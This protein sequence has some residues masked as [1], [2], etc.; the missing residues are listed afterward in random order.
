MVRN[1]LAVL[2]IGLFAMSANA[3]D[4]LYSADTAMTHDAGAFG[5][6]ANF[7][8]LM[9]NS[10]FDADGNKEDWGDNDKYTIMAV[11]ITVYY[12]IMDNLEVGVQPKFLMP[13]YECECMTR[14]TDT[15]EGSGIGDTWI[16]AKY[17]FMPEPMMTARLGF[18]IPTGS[19][20]YD[21]AGH[22]SGM[23]VDEDGDL[24]TGDGQ[25]DIDAALMFGAPA[26]PGMLDAA[27]GYRYRMAQEVT[28]DF[29][30]RTEYTYDYTPGSEIHFAAC[31]TYY[32][33]DMMNLRLGADGFFGA[34]DDYDYE[35]IE[36]HHPDAGKDTARNGVWINPGFDYMMENGMSL[37][38]D[39]HYPLMGQNMPAL[40]GFGAY[41]KWGM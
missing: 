11:P 1:I 36:E 6:K 2:L 8:Y 25:M 21:P 5:V 12:G 22:F 35:G 24:A 29:P 14:E 20:V 40:W 26:G 9:A 15:T 33:N 7:V 27:V 38:V 37:G 32:L 3:F 18:K 28:V 30:A 13:K 16:Y 4:Y 19:E 17:M 31:Y 34:D 10:S 23:P 39:M 41:V